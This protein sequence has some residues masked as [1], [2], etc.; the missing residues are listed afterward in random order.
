MTEAGKEQQE[1]TIALASERE[2]RMRLRARRL[3]RV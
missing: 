3:K 1:E 2:G